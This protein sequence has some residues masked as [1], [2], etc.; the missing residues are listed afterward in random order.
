M[1]KYLNKTV[2][3]MKD[4]TKKEYVYD[5]RKYA[6]FNCQFCEKEYSY[7][8]KSKHIKTRK[9]IKNEKLFL[10]QLELE[11]RLNTQN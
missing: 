9:H 6:K 7:A 4:G 5:T 2:K 3:I 10:L 8:S 11:N 1:P